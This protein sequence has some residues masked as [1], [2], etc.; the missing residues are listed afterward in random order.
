MSV[1]YVYYFGI[2][3]Y[4]I[5]KIKYIVSHVHIFTKYIVSHEKFHQI[6]KFIV[7]ELKKLNSEA[8]MYLICLS[9]N[10]QSAVVFTKHKQKRGCKPGWQNWLYIYGLEIYVNINYIIAQFID[11]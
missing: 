11:I 4:F 9:V 7:R 10:C 3:T 1:K 5:R 6:C 8:F 2:S